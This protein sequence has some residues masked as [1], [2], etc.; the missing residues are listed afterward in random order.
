MPKPMSLAQYR[1][2][3]KPKGQKSKLHHFK[4]DIFEAIDTDMSLVQIAD[5][6]ALHGV[7]ISKQSIHSWIKTHKKQSTKPIIPIFEPQKSTQTKP[8]NDVQDKKK[9]TVEPA[10][11]P[12]L[13]NDDDFYAHLRKVADKRAKWLGTNP[14]ITQET[15]NEDFIM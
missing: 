5:F 8:N 9:I 10:A 3:I 14:Y 4:S 7:K 11:A 15:T 12:T 13:T 6:L 2:T 1:A